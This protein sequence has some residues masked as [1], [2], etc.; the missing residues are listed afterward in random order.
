MNWQKCGYNDVAKGII[1][2]IFP[3]LGA[4]PPCYASLRL[5][6]D[7]AI[8][9][10]FAQANIAETIRQVGEALGEV[11]SWKQL[12]ALKNDHDN[13]VKAYEGLTQ[14]MKEVAEKEDGSEK[15]KNTARYSLVEYDEHQKDNWKGSKSIV[16][17]ENDEQMLDFVHE[18]LTDNTFKKKMYL[19]K[20]GSE[21]A[22][23]IRA[24][25]GINV[26][27]Y[28][29]TLHADEI[30]KVRT[31]HGDEKR[32]KL[33]G[34]RAILPDD[35][36]LIKEV[37]ESPERV[38][39]GD[40]GYQ[41]KPVLI[42]RKLID[43]S[44]VEVVAVVSKKHLDLRL[45]TM[46]AGIKKESIATTISEQADINTPEA[47]RGTAPTKIIAQ[48]ADSVNTKFSLKE[49]V[50]ETRDLIAVHNLMAEKILKAFKLG[51]FPMPSI[52]I[53]KAK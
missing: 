24:E 50:E 15:A 3:L 43:G 39:R 40:T 16:I 30:R 38:K 18:A 52:A 35:Y 49:E 22:A 31:D 34:Q 7:I 1:P 12:N 2:A 10:R 33:R 53:T 51:G 19:G 44:K 20:I 46:Y 48:G 23:Y 37:M 8:K 45:Q 27:N 36:L 4:V 17:Y 21:H 13:L 9:K 28:N 14:A 32:E 41:N 29:C 25:T 42:F 11:G 6:P 47:V 26:E 5:R